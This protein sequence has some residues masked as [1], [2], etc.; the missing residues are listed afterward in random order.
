MSPFLDVQAITAQET[1]VKAGTSRWTLTCWWLKFSAY[2]FE[3]YLIQKTFSFPAFLRRSWVSLL[4]L[5][6]IKR[7]SLC[8]SSESIALTAEDFECHIERLY[9]QTSFW[10]TCLSVCIYCI[11]RC[12]R[13]ST[14]YTHES[15][16]ALVQLASLSRK[17]P[18][19]WMRR[20]ES[21]LMTWG[22]VGWGGEFFTCCFEKSYSWAEERK[23]RFVS[24]R[25]Q[26][27]AA[28]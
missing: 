28:N 26:A 1:T 27:A 18:P 13:C 12:S 4:S 21:W 11:S 19:P 6:R 3:S 10:D 7:S 16:L 22:R 23:V 14:V 17:Q 5:S 24:R 9:L 2:S 25:W 15:H 20:P 8:R